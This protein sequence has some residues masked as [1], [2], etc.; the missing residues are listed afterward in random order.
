MS[1]RTSAQFEA[2]RKASIGRISNAALDL[3]ARKGY[4]ATS[5][6]QIAT[7]AGVS[8]GLLYNYFN[9]KEALLRH[10]ILEAVAKGEKVLSEA[11]ALPGGPKARL[12]QFTVGTFGLIQ[13][14]RDYWRLLSALALQPHVLDGLMPELQQKEGQAMEGFLA[15][16]REL[17]YEDPE[18]ELLLYQAMMDGVALKYMQAPE[19]Y[20]LGKMQTKILAHYQL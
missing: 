4:A 3:F 5:V 13:S 1:P 8:K 20:P 10:I 2:I 9:G 17:G 18:G 6:A 11:L 16:F 7:A 19:A 14:N 15:L 12:R